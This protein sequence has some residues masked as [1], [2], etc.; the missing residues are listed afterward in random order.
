MAFKDHL[1]AI[2]SSV[3]GAILSSVMGYDGI[4]V[5]TTEQGAPGL[6]VPSLL[7]EYTALLGQVRSAA[8]VLQSGS[9]EELVLS[10]ER[11]TVFS[12]PLT[13]DYFLLVALAPGANWGKARYLMRITAPRLRSEL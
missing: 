5:E 1:E 4:A 11:L 6:D 8:T 9:V 7:V 10:T 3:E 2:C 13:A 12:R